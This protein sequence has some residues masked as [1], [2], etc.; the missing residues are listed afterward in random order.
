MLYGLSICSGMILAFILMLRLMVLLE[1]VAAILALPCGVL[2]AFA[3]TRLALLL[4]L[5]LGH[6]LLLLLAHLL[7][8]LL[9]K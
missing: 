7:P 6:C 2:V 3:R 9:Q 8:L 5:L 1:V 4:V